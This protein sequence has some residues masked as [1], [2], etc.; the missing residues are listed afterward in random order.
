MYRVPQAGPRWPAVAG[1]VLSEGLGRIC[2]NGA[3]LAKP[4]LP[5]LDCTARNWT[6]HAPVN[7]RDAAQAKDACSPKSLK[8]VPKHF[9]LSGKWGV[10]SVEDERVLGSQ[11]ANRNVFKPRTLRVLVRGTQP[12][13]TINPAFQNGR[14]LAPPVGMEDQDEIGL[15]QRAAVMLNQW[16][17]GSDVAALSRRL[18]QD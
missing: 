6:K 3:D 14:R 11:Q 13:D 18:K 15:L 9:C 10:G 17:V 5:L 7:A 1:P 2:D 4:R 12:K 16:V 8:R